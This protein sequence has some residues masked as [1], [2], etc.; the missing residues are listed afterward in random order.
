MF[1]K[2]SISGRNEM[3]K[4]FN[5]FFNMRTFAEK[6]KVRKDY[7]Q[8]L[9]IP[10][11]ATEEEIK[12]AYRSLAK[13]FHPDVN[14][15][16]EK[17]EP[18]VEKFRDIAEA[19][20]VLSNKTLRLDYDTRMRNFP[21]IIYNA[22]KVKKMKETEMNRDATANQVKPGPMK[23]SYAEYRLEKLKEWRKQFNVDDLGFYK[24]GVPNKNQGSIRG[25]AE[26]PP[27][28]Y[29]NPWYHNESVH[30]NPHAR[31]HVSLKESQEHK[32]FMN[33]KIGIY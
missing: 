6:A 9:G 32:I 5:S 16:A 7:Y 26:A 14:V 4:S 11:S 8:I 21:E 29:H 3:F 15:G 27:G 31:P 10:K 20:A 12:T 22:E 17:H 24:G 23:G 13:R 33:C 28:V 19:Y 2:L 25:T 1:K 30:D 18:N